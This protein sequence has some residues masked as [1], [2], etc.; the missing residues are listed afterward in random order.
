MP[1][2]KQSFGIQAGEEKQLLVLLSLASNR[3]KK[4]DDVKMVKAN[5]IHDSTI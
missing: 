2:T 5:T 1:K 4:Y 3:Q